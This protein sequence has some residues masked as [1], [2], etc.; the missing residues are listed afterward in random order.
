MLRITQHKSKY[1]PIEVLESGRVKI[2]FDYE[3]FFDEDEEGNKIPSDVGTWT[4]AILKPQS[5]LEQ[6]KSFILDA[7]NKRTD[8][9]IVS[10]FVWRDMPVWL[11]SENQFNY[12]AA[13]D[14][15]VQTGGA[16]LPTVFKFGDNDNPIY[17]KFETVEELSD[18]YIKAMAYINEQLAIGWTKKDMIDWEKY[19]L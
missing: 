4:E 17:H 13:Y 5:S 2:N 14:L 16:N 19:K 8:E 6:I 1:V 9:K 10:G 12:K 7:I 18:F 3:P 11:S 15:A